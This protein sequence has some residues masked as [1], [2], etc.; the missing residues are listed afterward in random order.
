[1]DLI[2]WGKII[3]QGPHTAMAASP[4]LPVQSAFSQHLL[5]VT[6]K[7]SSANLFAPRYWPT[8]IGF[9]V[10][11]IVARLPYSLEMAIGSLLGKLMRLSRRRRFICGVNLELAFPELSENE[12]EHLSGKVFA[13]VGKGFIETAL[14]WFGSDRK[15]RSIVEIKGLEHLR[16]AHATGQGIMLLGSHFVPI[17]ICG[18]RLGLEYPFDTTY[19]PTHNAVFEYVMHHRRVKIY[20]GAIP[21]TDMRKIVKTVKS[22]GTIW[23][24]PDQN[25]GL[26][27]STFVPFFGV[28]TATTMGTSKIARMANALVVPTFTIR[29]PGNKGYTLHILPHLDNF[30]GDSPEE[31]TAR[32]IKLIEEW[33]RKYPDQYLWI[34]SRYKDHPEGGNNRY[35]RYADEYPD[36]EF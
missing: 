1:M 16:A 5:S 32:I 14:T 3:P 7:T 20:G 25:Y 22:G 30:P 26:K 11:W 28:Q 23:Y 13:S 2:Q 18:R 12:R 4:L 8:W 35:E 21:V 9:G 10:M 24:A 31:D 6:K 19:K 27:G 34:H 33:A 36:K 15:I 29:E 17:E